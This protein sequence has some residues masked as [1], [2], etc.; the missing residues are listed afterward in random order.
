MI[1]HQNCKFLKAAILLVILLLNNCGNCRNLTKPGRSEQ[2]LKGKTESL[3]DEQE[4]EIPVKNKGIP[5]IGNSC[6]MNSVI[7]I[8]ASFYRKP[9]EKKQGILAN[10]AI[11]MINTIT[12]QEEATPAEIR[13]KAVDFFNALKKSEQEGGIDWEPQCGSQED[14]AELLVKIFGWLE[15]PKAETSYKLIHPIT[16]AERWKASPDL[17][18]IWFIEIPADKPELKTMQDFFKNSL[19]PGTVEI[20]WTG[21]DANNVE[22]TGTPFLKNLHKLYGKM[23]IV[24]LKRFE[25]T[26]TASK[27]KTAIADPFALTIQKQQTADSLQ[28]LHYELVGFIEHSG[29]A[30]GGHYVAYTKVDG[31]WIYYSD[32]SVHD[33]SAAEVKSAAKNAYLFFYQ[34]IKI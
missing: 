34:Q 15:M 14:A 28:D 1:A 13:K 5:N 7:Q 24:S 23:L 3:N 33:A 4:P 26:K 19:A 18:S 29:G 25:F 30:G 8:L 2:T 27:I 21:H 22:A 10:A 6:Y 31:E 20:N 9:F 16:H 11:D 17:C 12:S 32:S